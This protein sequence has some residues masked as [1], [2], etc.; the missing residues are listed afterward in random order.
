MAIRSNNRIIGIL[1]NVDSGKTTLAETLLYHGGVLRS[2]G[3]VDHGDAF[4]DTG[5]MERQRGITIFSKIARLSLPGG[6]IILLD[7]PGHAD[8]TPETE[9][10]LAVLDYCILVINGADGITH[11]TRRLWD[12]LE[13]YNVPVF[14]FV[15]K[16]DQEGVDPGQVYRDLRREL[17]D[18][19]L[20]FTAEDLL[21]TEELATLSEPLL[22]AF[23]GS[24]SAPEALVRESIRQ[25]QVMPCYFGSA[26]KDQGVE[27]FFKGMIRWTVSPEYPEAFQA[28]V[29][30]ITREENQR[31]TWLKITGGTLKNK[32]LIGDEKINEIRLYSGTGFESTQSVS[33]GEICAVTGLKDTRA[34]QIIGSG[35]EETEPAVF[36]VLRYRVNLEEGG[37]VS[38]LIRLLSEIGEE[39]PDLDVTYDRE[40][41]SVFVR[42]MGDIMLEVLQD[43][44]ETRG[45]MKISM[46]EGSILYRETL[47]EAVTGIGHFE[48]LRHYA[49]V[50]LRIEPWDAPGVTLDSQCS[51]QDLPLV[52]QQQILRE[53]RH[54]EVPGVL[55]GLDLSH[56]KIT[57]IS[58]R[59]HEKHTQSGDF[60]E[61]AARALRQGLMQAGEMGA[62]RL[63]E[64]FYDFE[65]LTDSDTVGRIMT[66]LDRLGAEKLQALAGEQ[67]MILTGSGPVRTLRTYPREILSVTR[68]TARLR[69]EFGGFRP[70][71]AEEEILRTMDYDPEK[72]PHFPPGSIFCSQ[73]A[74]YYVPWDQV[75]AAAHIPP[76]K[77]KSQQAGARQMPAAGR[78]SAIAADEIDRILQQTF[79]ANANEK[80]QWRKR[81]SRERD[82]RMKPD[83]AQPRQS[84]PVYL[85]VDGYNVVHAW[86]ELAELAKISFDAAREKLIE[87]LH[88]YQGYTGE[89]VILVFD[90]W[91]VVGGAGSRSEQDQLTVVFTREHET[92][93]R[94]IERRAMEL[95]GTHPVKVVTS[96]AAEQM[97][98][99]GSGALVYSARRFREII[100]E[101][102][103]QIWQDYER[104]TDPVIPHRPMAEFLRSRLAREADGSGNDGADPP[105]AEDPDPNEPD[106][107]KDHGPK[108]PGRNG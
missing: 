18:R 89:Q 60:R 95:A 4:L 2:M 36:P 32:S 46:D 31:L 7:T 70:C 66:D 12:L 71:R 15:N 104:K 100:A 51:E 37:D 45:G 72:D 61:A 23:L 48:P 19:I 77:D 82:Q 65:I 55:A 94:Y 47:T 108:G 49:E 64:P 43:L 68:G 13:I 20:D 86:P 28:R 16:I 84:G 52:R 103:A 38:K 1:A 85:L 25:R 73:G 42:I 33:A 57:L 22:E 27:A 76:A 79:Y 101:I 59:E 44:V 90:A 39:L 96:D 40:T 99:S 102:A 34:G 54:L 105:A 69:F 75:E 88:D 14:V 41:A 92:A 93:D 58:G 78:G 11:Q 26:L 30:K 21:R 35:E 56:L 10:T 98:A 8:F 9:R 91:K 87:V 97:L 83:R 53:L 107:P 63:L 3:R 17:S 5:E 81:K 6:R 62:C 74:G 50:H 67:A 29:Y 80:K 106:R 24:G